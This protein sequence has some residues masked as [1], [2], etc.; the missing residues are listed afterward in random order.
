MKKYAMS[1]MFVGLSFC[2][3]AT[4]AFATTVTGRIETIRMSSGTAGSPRVSLYTGKTTACV[5][6]SGWFAYES[7]SSGVGLLMTNGVLEAYN[8]GK[9][10][11]IVGTGTCDAF[12][13]ERV[14]YIDL[15]P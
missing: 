4:A 2:L 1:G 3:L 7:A 5:G 15:L 9:T 12:G 13:V 11:R 8:D 10:V 6:A 14:N